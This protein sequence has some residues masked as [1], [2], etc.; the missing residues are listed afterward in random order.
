MPADRADPASGSDTVEVARTKMLAAVPPPPPELIGPEAAAGRTL[1]E[2]L[3]ASRAQPPFRSSAMDGYG[4]RAADL[5]LGRF[6]VLGEA[7]A[8]KG[9]AL[10]PLGAAGAIRIFTGAPVPDGV[11]LVVPQERARR[12][13]E[14]VWL[15]A[16]SPRRTNIRAAGVA[17]KAGDLL[18]R[19]GTPLHA[20]PVRLIAAA[21]GRAGGG[22]RPT[23]VA[24]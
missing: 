22:T 10:G 18:V 7:L 19:G 2:T 5:A 24:A 12:E 8:G 3:L 1:A 21:G 11:D 6:T 17:F 13:G 15:D 14:T 23:R 16:P 9:Y 20:R 4:V